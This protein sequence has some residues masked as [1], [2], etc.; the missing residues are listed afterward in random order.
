MMFPIC[1][2]FAG[3]DDLLKIILDEDSS[4]LKGM[5]EDLRLLEA[6]DPQFFLERTLEC[7][8][9]ELL[10]HGVAFNRGIISCHRLLEV[11]VDPLL[12]LARKT[13]IRPAR[14]STPEIRHLRDRVFVI[15]SR[16][17]QYVI[18]GCVVTGN[19]MARKP[20]LSPEKRMDLVMELKVTGFFEVGLISCT[21]VLSFKA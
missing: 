1:D 5:F 12:S 21:V 20:L 13:S 18:G 17:L 6:H 7:A 10:T 2:T 19:L 14:G 8:L 4:V 11:V 9:P 3:N 16:A 15:W